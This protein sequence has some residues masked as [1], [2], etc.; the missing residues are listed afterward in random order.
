MLR[1]LARAA[2]DMIAK[3]VRIRTD[4]GKL[5]YGRVYLYDEQ[6]KTLILKVIDDLIYTQ[7][8]EEVI[9]GMGVYNVANIKYEG[10]EPNAK[11]ITQ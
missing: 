10:E 3:L 5:V 6:S 11:E 2:N 9:T 8:K 7:S 1:N 4:Y